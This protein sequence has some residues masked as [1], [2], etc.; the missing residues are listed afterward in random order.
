MIN[1]CYIYNLLKQP[2]TKP[3]TAPNNLMPIL[4]VQ[5]SHFFFIHALF[6]MKNR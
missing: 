5:I 2:I 6:Q 1:I 3:I 4:Q